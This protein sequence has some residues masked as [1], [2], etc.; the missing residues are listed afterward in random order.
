M[1]IEMSGVA[2]KIQNRAQVQPRMERMPTVAMSFQITSKFTF[3]FR[4]LD[5]H[6]LSRAA[7]ITT[8]NRP[9][10]LQ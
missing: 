3:S 8:E 2:E 5:G 4:A 10:Y 6:K 1:E 9:T 7:I